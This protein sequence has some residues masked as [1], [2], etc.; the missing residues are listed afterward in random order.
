M[1]A[2]WTNGA[3]VMQTETWNADGTV[4]DIHY[5][6]LT[7]AY[8]DYDVVYANNKPVSATYSNGMTQTWSYNA[9]G[10]LHEL[11][12]TG[13]TGAR[14]TAS[15]TLYANGKAVSA[16]WTNGSTIVQTETWNADGTVHDIHYYGLTGAYSDYDVVYANN[17]PASATY[18]N[19][20]T[21]TWS[22]N[23]DG[24]LHEL[25]VTGITGARYTASDTLY[26]NGKAVSAVWTNGSTIVQTETWNA[27]G[28]GPRHPLLRA[29]RRLQRLRCRLCQQQAGERDVLKRH[30][31]D[32]E[33]QR[34]RLAARI[35][36][37]GHYRG[38]VHRERHAL[39][40]RQGGERG[41][42]QRRTV[43]QTETWNADG[44]VH[45]IHYYGLTGAYTDYDV[46][47]ANNKPVSATY[48]NG[49]TATWSYNADGSLHELVYN[50]ITGARWTASDTL[51]E[52]GKPV[53]EVW[54]SAAAPAKVR[55]RRS[56]RARRGI[57]TARCMTSIISASAGQAYTDYDVIYA[58]NK[59]ISA[60]Y[61]N[62]M[63]QTWAY[64]SDGS[65]VVSL[66]NIQGGSYTS[67][68]SIYDPKN[69]VSGHLALQQTTNTNGT[70]ALRSYDDGLTITIGLGGANVQ[71]PSFRTTAPSI[72]TS[73]RTRSLP[74][75][76]EP[77]TS[78]FRPASGT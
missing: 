76:R 47:Y 68:A 33:L 77:T 27:D 78:F 25:I 57:R 12:V 7:G 50:G 48:S 23:A 4:H 5:Y 2:V 67:T 43:M 51:Y 71:L 45:D 39:R 61:S 54:T 49:M 21:Q 3:T 17:K 46:V 70:Q 59:P 15:D 62:G 38:T 41:L 19:G 11:I 28:T 18:S 26:A 31:A 64:N 9:D 60:L 37:H 10:S 8:T 53:S 20:M 1:S 13:I 42:D 65:S 63:T 16:V 14:Y 52:N 44:T 29:H 24:S 30:D 69:D 75:A 32:L 6:G 74:A 40:Q 55:P 72:L 56:C 34:R 58:N 35:D 66:N 73:S 22:Y 36:R